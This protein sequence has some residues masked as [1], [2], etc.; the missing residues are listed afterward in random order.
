MED[1]EILSHNKWRCIYHIVFA[2]RYRRTVIY[3]EIKEEFGKI[4]FLGQA[5]RGGNGTKIEIFI[6]KFFRGI[7]FT[8]PDL[9]RNHDRKVLMNK[10]GIFISFEMD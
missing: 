1:M 10:L 8:R 3:G 9:V 2:P 7:S 4:L 6:V 5:A